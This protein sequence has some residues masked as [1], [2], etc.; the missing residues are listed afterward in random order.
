MHIHRVVQYP[1]NP[2]SRAIVVIE[3]MMATMSQIAD[4]R[5]DS[6]KYRP[7]L[8]K[9]RKPCKRCIDAVNVFVRDVQTEPNGALGM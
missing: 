5:A 3:D 8:R 9:F 2:D 6:W 1:G 7:G 4:R